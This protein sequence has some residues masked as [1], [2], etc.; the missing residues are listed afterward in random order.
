MS[1]IWMIALIQQN[2]QLWWKLRRRFWA[3]P[4]K[5]F[6]SSSILPPSFFSARDEVLY[7]THLPRIWE[8]GRIF[9]F[10]CS[11][12]RSLL[13]LII[14]V[15]TANKSSICQRGCEKKNT[16]SWAAA[17]THQQAP[18]SSDPCGGRSFRS[19]SRPFNSFL[20][21]SVKEPEEKGGGLF[22]NARLI[23]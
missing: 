8:G 7:S 12:A 10:I 17:G 4:R 13:L 23:K 14:I 11:F 21:L 6:P 19:Q 18:S 16:I 15:L 3:D 20:L 1:M 5:A 9:I 2:W 22:D